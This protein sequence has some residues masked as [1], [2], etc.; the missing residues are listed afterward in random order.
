M[1]A[2]NTTIR[3][4]IDHKPMHGYRI[5]VWNLTN[6]LPRSKSAVDMLVYMIQVT[7][8]QQW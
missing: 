8:A 2:W 6:C 1:L 7:S 4:G 5:N 3:A